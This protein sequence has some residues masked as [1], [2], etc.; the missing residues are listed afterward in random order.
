MFDRFYRAE[1]SHS[2]GGSGLGLAPPAVSS[3]RAAG[4]R[5]SSASG[6][7]EALVDCG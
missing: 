4:P 5:R 6:V 3:R 2:R 7:T 1:K